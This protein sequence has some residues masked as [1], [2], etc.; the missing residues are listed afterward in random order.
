MSP[1]NHSNGVVERKFHAPGAAP[2]GLGGRERCRT[3]VRLLTRPGPLLSVGVLRGQGKM[4]VGDRSP[5]THTYDT[6][7]YE[8]CV[9]VTIADHPPTRVAA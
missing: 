7:G 5:M 8:T 1:D 9:S 2:A 6:P 3:P 4:A